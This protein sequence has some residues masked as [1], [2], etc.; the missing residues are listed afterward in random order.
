VIGAVVSTV[1]ASGK[2]PGR[3]GQ[4]VRG[5]LNGVLLGAL[6]DPTL[7]RLDEHYYERDEMYR[8]T[9]W[10][11]AGLFPWEHDAVKAHFPP[12]GRVVVPA[13]GGGREVL[14]LL[15]AG[16]DAIGYEPH[17]ALADYAERF[18]AEQGY[19]G[20][21]HRSPRDSFPDSGPCDAVLVGWGAY[22]LISPRDVR[23]EFL[24]G[25]GNAVASGGPI[26]LSGF[27]QD[28]YGRDLRLTASLARTGR[29]LRREVPP[30]LGD[31]LAP[32]RVHVFTVETLGQEVAAAGLQMESTVEVGVAHRR[33]SYVRALLRAP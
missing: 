20:R 3:P 18:L 31:T 28:A 26:L 22:T 11:G 8:T 6:S 17:P 14:A 33:T 2:I 24:R 16:Y 10:N 13:C 25:A 9:E 5:V 12:Q 1:L 29:R 7:K 21:A 19:P 15:R 30:E 23:V 32:S 4:A 27:A